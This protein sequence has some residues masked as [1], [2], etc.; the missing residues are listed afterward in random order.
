[1]K[2]Y[3]IAAFFSFTLLQKL[4]KTVITNAQQNKSANKNKYNISQ[5]LDATLKVIIDK[6]MIKYL[7]IFK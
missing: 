7:D 2:N 3:L 6:S 4:Q 5:P 1:M